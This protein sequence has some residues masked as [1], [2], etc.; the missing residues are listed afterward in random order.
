MRRSA[1]SIVLLLAACRGDAP[2]TTLA[3]Y[4]APKSGFTVVVDAHGVVP[5]DEDLMPV[6]VPTVAIV[7]PRTTAGHALRIDVNAPGATVT[8]GTTSSSIRWKVPDLEHALAGAGYLTIDHAEIE[9]TLDVINGVSYGRKGTHM[10]GQTH[11]LAVVK[12]DFASHAPATVK[13]CP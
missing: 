7:C 11:H 3:T 2:F 13:V 5:A 9:E 1:S 10:P 4:D 8:D 12:V 6:G